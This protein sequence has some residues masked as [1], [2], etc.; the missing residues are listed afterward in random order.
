MLHSRFAVGV[1]SVA[2]ACILGATGVSHAQSDESGKPSLSLRATP[3][4]GFTPLRVRLVVEVRGGADD[5]A[6]FYCPTI[7]WDWD[8]GTVSESGV[9]CD[10]YE[11]GKSQIRRQFSTTHIFRQGGRY[12]V[13]FRLKQKDK[14]VGL[15]R[16][17]LQVQQSGER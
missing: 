13:S 16:A 3:P 2:G 4:I 8:D 11:A 12:Q 7:E 17:G 15:A 10:P 5:Y 14:V 1:F 6:D 9:D